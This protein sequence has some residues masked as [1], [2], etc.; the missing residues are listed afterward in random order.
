MSKDW[1]TQV[2]HKVP[3]AD[4]AE[5]KRQEG[6]VEGIPHAREIALNSI[7]KFKRQGYIPVRDRKD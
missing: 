4:R 2:N 7:E 3:T 1:K 6:I 5:R